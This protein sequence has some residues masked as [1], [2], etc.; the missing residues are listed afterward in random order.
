MRPPPGIYKTPQTE[1]EA[2][3]AK[4]NEEPVEKPERPMPVI[5]EPPKP[6][7]PWERGLRQAK[8]VSY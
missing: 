7:S 4:E 6:E 2:E 5:Q 3:T 1:A 8:E